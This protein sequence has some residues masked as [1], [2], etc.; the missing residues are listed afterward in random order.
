M[1]TQIIVDNIRTSINTNDGEILEIA[2]RKLKKNGISFDKSSVHLHKRSVDARKKQNITFVS[3]VVAETDAD[4]STLRAENGIRF[5]PRTELVFEN[6]T[7][8]MCG[9]PYIIGFGPAGIFCALILAEHGLRPVV[10]ERGAPV[11]ERVSKVEKFYKTG[12]LDTETNIQFGA[13]GAGT[14]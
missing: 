10:L 6:G 3:S 8:E 2:Q 9:R 5:Q 11:K 14:F 12:I 1:K 13:G 4:I 7:Q